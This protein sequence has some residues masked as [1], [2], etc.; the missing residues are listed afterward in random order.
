M[1]RYLIVVYYWSIMLFVLKFQVI[2]IHLPRIANMSSDEIIHVH[3][4]KRICSHMK[5]VKLQLPI[6]SPPETEKLFTSDEYT[7]HLKST[8]SEEN[9]SLLLLIWLCALKFNWPLIFDL[10]CTFFLCV[11]F[12]LVD[13]REMLEESPTESSTRGENSSGILQVKSNPWKYLP[14]AD[15]ILDFPEQVQLKK[16]SRQDKLV[17][18][19]SLIDYIPNLGEK[20]VS[21]GHESL[22]F[23][24]NVRL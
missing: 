12:G 13:G 7:W 21:T 15:D 4:L 9:V 23:E 16:R 8:L 20:N 14:I 18:V 17:V 24:L 10:Y 19:A 3:D 5:I 1:Y 11:Y 22:N 2:F 6:Q